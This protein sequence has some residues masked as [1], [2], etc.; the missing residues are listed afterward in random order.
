MN[1]EEDES[2]AMI[3]R[4]YSFW[5][6]H[7]MLHLLLV[8]TLLEIE[9]YPKRLFLNYFFVI[10]FISLG[11]LLRIFHD[12]NQLVLILIFALPMTLAYIPAY[13]VVFRND[14]YLKYFIRFEKKDALWHKK[15]RRR[16]IAFCIG[17][18]LSFILGILCAIFIATI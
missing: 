5:S 1:N 13:R 17:G 8:N 9:K 12:I 6:L 11:V 18:V 15:W 2:L 10:S 16:T 7:V 14:K 4:V 3:F